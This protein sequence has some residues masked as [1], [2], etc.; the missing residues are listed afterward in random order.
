MKMF[1]LKMLCGKVPFE[2]KKWEIPDKL[3]GRNLRL[4]RKLFVEL[5]TTMTF[6]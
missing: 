1:E 5:P 2:H 3:D 6:G 4:I